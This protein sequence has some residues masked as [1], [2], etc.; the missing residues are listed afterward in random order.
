[1]TGFDDDGL[2]LSGTLII[3]I[4]PAGNEPYRVERK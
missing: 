2:G 4:I 3:A 1:M